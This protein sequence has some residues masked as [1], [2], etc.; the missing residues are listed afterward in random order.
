M[1]EQ[2]LP[3]NPELPEDKYPQ[4]S[5]E[6]SQEQPLPSEP[7]EIFNDSDENVSIEGE[8]EATSEVIIEE[9]ETFTEEEYPH[10]EIFDEDD[11]AS[12]TVD[13]PFKTSSP[14]DHE[15]ALR[16]FEE[17][18]LSEVLGQFVQRPILTTR[19][20]FLAIQSEQQRERSSQSTQVLREFIETTPE[21]PSASPVE[22]PTDDNEFQQTKQ[23]QI[24]SLS[25]YLLALI[26]AV[27]GSIIMITSTNPNGRMESNEL[28]AGFPYFVIAV[29]LWLGVELL[30]NTPTLYRIWKQDRQFV[31]LKAIQIIPSLWLFVHGLTFLFDAS[32]ELPLDVSLINLKVSIGIQYMFLGFLLF[33]IFT[34]GKWVVTTNNN[35]HKRKDAPQQRIF[36]EEWYTQIHPLRVLIGIS[37]GSLGLFVFINSAGNNLDTPTFYLWLLSV[38]LMTMALAPQTWWSVPKNIKE[39]M[40]WRFDIK[41]QG[42]ILLVFL[43]FF[44]LGLFFRFDRLIGDPALGTSIPQEMTS[45]HVEKLLDSQRVQDGA[46]NIFFANNGGREPI[47]MY[48]M[49]LISTLTGQNVSHDMLKILA[50]TEAMITLP[51]LFFFGYELFKRYDR[52]F[53]ILMGL[54]L[55]GLIATSYWHLTIGRLALRIILTP[56]VVTLLMLY[57]TRAIRDNQLGDYIKAGLVLGFGLYTYQAV[58]MLPVVVLVGLFI[59]FIWGRKDW[60][61]R[62]RVILNGMALIMISFMAFVP[63]FRYS[64]ENPDMFWRRTTGRLMGDDIVETQDASGQTIQREA[65]LQDRIN[66]FNQNVPQLLNNIRNAVLMF[67]WKG[68][69][70]FINGVPN[71]PVLDW[72]TGGLFIVGLAAWLV[73]CLRTRDL[74]FILVPMTLLIMLLPSALSIAF[75]VENPSF[76]RTSGA[77]P[78]VYLIIALPVALIAQQILKLGLK[79]IGVALSTLWIG[80]VV[81]SSYFINSNFYFTYYPPVYISST[82]PYSQAGTVLRDFASVNGYGNAF[83]LAYPFWWDHRAIGLEA[84]LIGKWENG[85]YDIDS[86][87]T[88]IESADYIPYFMRNALG[89]DQHPLNPNRDLLFFYS[90]E[91]ESSSRIIRGFFPTGVETI[92][93]TYSGKSYML[94]RVPALG[95]EGLQAFLDAHP[96]P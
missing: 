82:F 3:Q 41:T 85:V 93:D 29:L 91:D 94:Y 11:F 31:V 12:V 48:L 68:D 60:Q 74:G 65:T 59:A 51:L 36:G 10:R 27:T 21:Q 77:L 7:Q 63:L 76:T 32:D 40:L 71:Y 25:R 90:V 4:S 55:V 52:R 61:D 49:A 81:F 1:P 96:V 57:L 34:V 84:G 50:T 70:G 20:F 78:M 66:A 83:M 92:M 45:D 2:D 89:N 30:G 17:L 6:H 44:G 8:P 19:A 38:F 35:R 54:I 53:A 62:L 5:D 67:N 42:W 22:Q 24:F 13:E 58:R 75:P 47:Q 39:F 72:L 33:M 95:V 15:Q 73:L 18:T 28:V 86:R 23:W 88:F 80:L 64:V 87:D 14:S 26:S 37:G 79:R 9:Q 56:L 69:V 43:L 16:E 46:R